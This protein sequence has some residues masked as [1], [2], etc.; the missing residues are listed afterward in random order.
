MIGSCGLL[1]PAASSGP[2]GKAMLKLDGKQ[3]YLVDDDPFFASVLEKYLL[4]SGAKV[5]IFTDSRAALKETVK[6]HP[7]CLVT[8]LMMPNLDGYEL[9]TRL[10]AQSDLEGLKIVVAS[11]KGFDFDQRRARQVGA[12]GYLVKPI[13]KQTFL[14]EL[15][16]ALSPKLGLKFWGVHGTLPAPGPKTLRYGGNTS[17]VSITL[18]NQTILVFD[19]G[20]GIKHLGDHLVARGGRLKA[21]IFISHPHWDHINALPFFAPLYLQGNSIEILGPA[22]G[23]IHM[24]DLIGAQMD[25]LYFPITMDE[26][27]AAVTFRDLREET[28]SF[29]GVTISTLLLSHPGNCLGYR[30]E[31]GE[32][33]ICYVTDNELFPAGLPQ[34]NEHYISRLTDFV[35]GADVL[36]TDTTYR[37]DDYISKVGWGHSC[38]S[39]VADLAHKAQVKELHLFHH[40]PN[41]S[42]DIIDQ[43]LA[44]TREALAKRASAVQVVAPAEG[45]VAHF[46][47]APN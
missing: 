37:D 19:A 25:S 36:I 27:A 31:C 28:I 18:P 22:H 3:I 39:E 2:M 43:K 29:D 11:A 13:D 23:D 42:D 45:D 10:R 17:C 7:D 15:E 44:E 21:K 34:R 4:G 26:F 8:D 40:D 33:S 32:T 35:A 38:V 9:C 47:L 20:S 14:D 12:D 41:D 24:R 46:R 30:L 6:H 5:R 16:R 1:G